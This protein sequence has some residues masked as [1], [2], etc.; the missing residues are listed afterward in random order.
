MTVILLGL[1]YLLLA[2]LG[3]ACWGLAL[4]RVRGT[5]GDAS[6][7]R[8]TSLLVASGLAMLVARSAVVWLLAEA[9][10]GF[11]QEKAVVGLPTSAAA[12][13]LAA[14]MWWM[15]RHGAVVS[16]RRSG[17]TAG[18]MAGAVTAATA[19]LILTTGLGA[20]VGL[21]VALVVLVA[22]V[23]AGVVTT[24]IGTRHSGGSRRPVVAAGAAAVAVMAG[25]AVTG[26]VAGAGAGTLETGGFAGGE[27]H[28]HGA[29]A[30]TA[31]DRRPV[32]VTDLTSTPPLS[33][34]GENIEVELLARQQEVELPS[35]R[36]IDA[37]TFG[38]LA[39]PAI[40]ARVG[41]TL[42]V[43]LANVDVEAGVTVHWHGYPVAN[44]FDGV[45]GVT[46]DAVEPG[47]GFR[48]DLPMTQPGTYWYH[49][50]QRG[51][52][53]VVSGLYGTL[54]VQPPTGPTEDVDLTLPVHTFS[55]T[56]VVGTSDVLEE[57]AVA[58][59]K[60]VRLR[61]VNTDQ[62]PRTFAVQGAAFRVAALDGRD[63]ASDPQV[64]RALVVPAGGRT[65]VVLVMPASAVRIGVHG[66][67][68]GGVALVPRSGAEIPALA[69][70]ATAFD[71]LTDL[72]AGDQRMTTPQ[73]HAAAAIDEAL[74]D[75]GFDVERTL[76]LD[77]LPRIVQGMPNYAYTVDGRVYPYIE[78]TLVDVGDTVRLRF[79]N[80]SFE[81]HPMHPHGHAVRVLSVDGREPTQP[82]WLDTFDVG[83]GEVWEV[84][85]YSDNPGIWM[86]HCHNLEH[87]ALGMVTHL[88]YRGVTTS[89]EHGGTAGNS[90]E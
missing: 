4:A 55:G 5:D 47:G 32:T 66:D 37:W 62:T 45:A 56:V 44:A 35:G 67:R 80:R 6:R 82:L 53:G 28:G 59:G 19:E 46:Q 21:D 38:E 89:F 29:D 72:T 42:S 51:S 36:T 63:V 1:A 75:E 34:G 68:S 76:I 69:I 18:A 41:D 61:F 2:C 22:V 60:S 31:G 52:Q 84:A 15:P 85:L 57:H 70:P 23:G 17:V 12:S 27:A 14:M 78:P 83:P 58:Q 86:D 25:V 8:A 9:D 79:V 77:R 54:V 71:P 87:A 50:H 64:D 16:V 74:G 40:V 10:P 39:G 30:G 88:A 7:R 20:P 11:A 65:D 24:L 90:P 26:F 13:V 33:S 43:R 49:T 73:S 48:A 81:T 3:A